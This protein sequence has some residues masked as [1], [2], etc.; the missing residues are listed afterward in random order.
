MISRFRATLSAIGWTYPMRNSPCCS[1]L[2]RSR[3]GADINQLFSWHRLSWHIRNVSLHI[4]RNSLC[5]SVLQCLFSLQTQT[6][7]SIDI[8]NE[9]LSLLQCV[10]AIY[11][12]CK[13]EQTRQLTYAEVQHG[14]WLSFTG[15]DVTQWS[16]PILDALPLP[17]GACPYM[18]LWVKYLFFGGGGSKP[19]L[20]I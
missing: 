17:D 16:H 18:C 11:P 4:T 13:H 12:C 3:F 5:S 9:E 2:Q 15:M 20:V 19:A 7:V 6:K 1:V 14:N 8:R 10:A